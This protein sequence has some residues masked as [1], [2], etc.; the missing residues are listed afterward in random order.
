MSRARRERRAIA[1]TASRVIDPPRRAASSD[2]WDEADRGTRSPAKTLLF[3]PLPSRL[4]RPAAPRGR[5]RLRNPRETAARRA[6]A[7]A[8]LVCAEKSRRAAAGERSVLSRPGPFHSRS[9]FRRTNERTNERTNDAT[10][11]AFQSARLSIVER[12][13]F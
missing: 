1:A 10:F 13:P 4:S 12:E 11:R 6:A 8:K 5:G 2:I 9:C 7:R 3:S